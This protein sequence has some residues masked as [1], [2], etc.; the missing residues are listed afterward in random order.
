[1]KGTVDNVK[2]AKNSRDS[3]ADP[4]RVK[5]LHNKYKR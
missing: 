3:L 2:T 5:R 1:M 4:E